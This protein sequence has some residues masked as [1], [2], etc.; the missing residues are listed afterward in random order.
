MSSGIEPL[1]FSKLDV[2][3]DPL[4]DAVL[5]SGSADLQ[6]NQVL[7]FEFPPNCGWLCVGIG[8]IARLCVNPLLPTLMWI[9]FLILSC[10]REDI[11][12]VFRVFPENCSTCS[13]RFQCVNGEEMSS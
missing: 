13:C 5:K 9:F 7:D 4:S 6:L 12:L 10:V 11:Q 3:N 2:L 1:W 8:F